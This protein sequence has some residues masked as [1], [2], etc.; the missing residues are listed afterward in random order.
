[1]TECH[2]RKQIINQI[3]KMR[4]KNHGHGDTQQENDNKTLNPWKFFEKK[5]IAE[6]QVVS[7][8]LFEC[9]LYREEIVIFAQLNLQ[10]L[11]LLPH[12]L[13]TTEGE[14]KKKF[15]ALLCKW[16]NVYAHMFFI[17]SPF[18]PQQTLIGFVILS[19]INR[20]GVALST[21]KQKKSLTITK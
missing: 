11:L 2:C 21:R 8:H 19:I 17:D 12:H 15:L 5:A 16:G 4:G 20:P 7:T 14:K 13:H 10:S 6:K 1:M 3:A 9:T 18:F